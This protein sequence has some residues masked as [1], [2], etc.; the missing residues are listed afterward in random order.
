MLQKIAEHVLEILVN[1]S[2]DPEI[3]ENL[4]TDDKFLDVIL[5]HITVCLARD[6][7]V[8]PEYPLR[9]LAKH[10]PLVQ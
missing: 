2:G 3:L 6:E 8:L 9:I 1:L 7:D 5:L 4:A 10:T